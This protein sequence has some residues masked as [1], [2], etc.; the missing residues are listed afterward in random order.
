VA[1]DSDTRNVGKHDEE[2]LRRFLAARD[3][4]DAAQMRGWWDELV[5]DFFDRMENVVD[6]THAGRLNDE[7]HELAVQLAMMRFSARLITTFRGS[8]IGELV[9]AC[10]TLA[11]GI[12]IDVQRSS[13]R[14]RRHGD[15]SLDAGWDAE[16]NDPAPSWESDESLRRFDQHQRADETREFLAWALPQVKEERRRVLEFTFHGA[17]VSEIAAELDIT[18]DNAYQRRSRGM[19][20]LKKLKEQ[21]DA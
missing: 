1:S 4:G 5:L 8:S 2:H 9:N 13:M 3:Q 12:C 10:H 11:H 6:A 14:Q 15:R 19:K 7:E 21:F 20:D 17:E 16:S 18:H